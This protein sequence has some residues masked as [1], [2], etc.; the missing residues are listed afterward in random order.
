M[1]SQSMLAGPVHEAEE[2]YLAR[3]DIHTSHMPFPH[4]DILKPRRV[5][6]Y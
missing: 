4:L 6:L 1:R 3:L 2:T 5:V